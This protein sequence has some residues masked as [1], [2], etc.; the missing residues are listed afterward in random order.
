MAFAKTLLRSKLAWA[1]AAIVLLVGAYALFGFYAAPRIVRSQAID[2]VRETY[3]RELAIGEVRIHPFKLQAE[4]KDVAIPDADGGPLLGFG[5]L[6]VDLEVSSL[7]ERAIVLRDIALD[8][9]RIRAVVRPDGSVNLADLAP[10][11]DGTDE[12]PPA[13]WV[14]SFAL[15]QGEVDF[16]DQARRVPIERRFAPVAFTLKD[17]RTTPE[18]GGFTLAARSP[19]D[20][21][22]EWSGRFVLAPQI[23]SQGEFKLTDLRLPGV[24]ELLGDTLPFVVPQGQMDL[25]GRYDLVLGDELQLSLE[26][27]QVALTELALRAHGVDEDWVS[28]PALTVADV[29]VAMPANTVAVGGITLDG[30]QARV[31]M[32]PDGTLNTDQL[33]AGPAAVP[34]TPAETAAPATADVAATSAPTAAPDAAGASATAT[35]PATPATP[36][37]AASPD[38]TV[39]IGSVALRDAAVDFEDRT[40]TPAARFVLAPLSATIRDASLDLTQPLPLE[41]Q[42][43]ING[44]ANLNGSGTL[45]PETTAADLAIEIT[46]FELKDLQPYAN[47]TTDLTIQRGTVGAKGRFAMAPAGSGK[48]EMSF[49]GNVSLAGFGSTDNT[50]NEDFVNFDRVELSKLEFTLAPDALSIDRVDVMKPFA[51]VII[52][53]DGVLNAAAVFDP[54]GTA[55]AV[56]AAQAEAAAKAAEASRKKTRAEIR[57]AK[58]AEAEAAKARAAAP[59]ASPLVETGMRIRIREV[60]IRDGT[61]D[62]SDFNVQPNFAAAVQS[63]GGTITGMSSDP[64]SRA[65]VKLGGNVGEFSPVS[66]EGSVQPFAYDRHTDIALRFENIS[67]PVFNPYSGKFAGYNIARGKLTTDLHYRIDARQLEAQHKIRIDQLEWGEATAAKDEATL[68]VKFATSLLKDADGVISLDIPVTGTLDDPK[69]RIGPIVWQIVKNILTKAVTA[70][71]KALGALFKGAEEAQFV[72]FA[73][74]QS[75]LDAMSAERLAALG[76]SLA[77]KPDLKLDVPIATDPETDGR[78]L[79]EARFQAERAE[80]VA[81]VLGGKKR[82]RQQDA[83]EPLPAFDSLEPERQ[84]EVLTALYAKLAGAPPVLP[85]PSVAA[86]DEL[87]RKERKARDLQASIDWLNAETR[88]RATPLPTDLELLAQARAAAIQK[89]LL[90]DTGLEPQRVFPARNGKVATSEGKVRLELTVR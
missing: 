7:W 10:P 43:A 42:A 3:G 84:V 19:N 86:D 89:A 38:W 8:A 74:G 51:R 88:A 52:S 14:Q 32:A 20:E 73:P 81:T 15:T 18:G 16:V 79:A 78:A 23:A 34:A 77:P 25:A 60:A 90:T 55:A 29:K 30:M 75:S 40:V 5:R 59:P 58:A 71:F 39:A 66:I 31:W 9:P 62:F 17:F 48:P 68:P 57:A 12:P 4:I 69:F 64:N 13:L 28:I 70:P 44:S 24:A 80:A 21:Q 56:A 67:L 41:F 61:M 1:A 37:S 50:L 85:E 46:G 53:A 47:G 83:A 76:K 54:E 35:T 6:F 33:F 87:S 82:A 27:P 63:L 11:D 22:F 36:A 72:D 49:A 45:V 2:Y 65:T 26:L